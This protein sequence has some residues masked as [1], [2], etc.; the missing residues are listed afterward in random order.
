[1]P[2][3]AALAIDSEAALSRGYVRGR[4]LPFRLKEGEA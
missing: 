3:L 2:D 4:L 1:L